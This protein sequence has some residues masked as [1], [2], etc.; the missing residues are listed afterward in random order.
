[1][2]IKSATFCLFWIEVQNHSS[3]DI[4]SQWKNFKLPQWGRKIRIPFVSF[5]R[6]HLLLKIAL[7]SLLLVDTNSS[8]LQSTFSA[9]IWFPKKRNAIRLIWIWKNVWG[10]VFERVVLILTN[11]SRRSKPRVLVSQVGP[12]G[13]PLLLTI[14]GKGFFL[15]TSIIRDARYTPGTCIFY[16]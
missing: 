4:G 14:S 2:L 16:K 7:S 9:R 5:R 13:T 15:T 1:M 8:I 11:L 12:N 10:D 3:C 6:P